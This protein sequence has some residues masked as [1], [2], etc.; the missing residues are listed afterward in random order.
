[1]ATLGTTPYPGQ[2][3]ES[4]G[5]HLNR[6]AEVV[7][8]KKIQNFIEPESGQTENLHTVFRRDYAEFLRGDGRILLPNKDLDTRW[9]SPDII[10][11]PLIDSHLYHHYQ[12]VASNFGQIGMIPDSSISGGSN[13][14]VLEISATISTKGRGGCTIVLNG[15]EGKYQFKQNPFKLG[16]T[17]FDSDD[18]VFV[19]LSGLDGQLHRVFTG[20]ITTVEAHTML[21]G[22]IKTQI[23]IHCD[24]SLKPLTQ[25]RTAVRPSANLSES[26][27]AKFVGLAESYNASM[28]HVVVSQIMGR[29][30]SNPYTIPG[31][32]DQLLE[33]R[34]RAIS[35]P[36]PSFAS[37]SATNP[38]AD[39]A[40]QEEQLRDSIVA[41][42]KPSSGLTPN[43]DYFIFSGPA[44][45][46]S[47]S[48]ANDTANGLVSAILQNPGSA[49]GSVPSYVFG[50]A[51]RQTPNFV[52][53]TDSFSLIRGVI[54]SVVKNGSGASNVD[55][56][57]LSFVVAGIKQ[58]TYR[59]MTTSDVPLLITDWKDGYS[60]CKT[61]ADQ[62]YFEF[63]ADAHGIAWFR[64]LNTKLPSDFKLDIFKRSTDELN[65]A[66]RVGIEYWLDAKYIQSPSYSDTDQGIYSIAYVAGDH[67]AA[68]EIGK[69]NVGIAVDL[70][71]FL[72]L[73]P[74]VAPVRTL[75]NVV[76]QEAV[77]AFARAYLSRINANA[78]T[79][80]LVYV[81]DS[82]I[83]VGNP[84]FIPTRNTIYY[85]SSITHN[86]V[87]GSTYTMSMELE[88]GRR[89]IAIDS[90]SP[91]NQNNPIA[92]LIKNPLLADL[93]AHK[94]L[95]TVLTEL[96]N[97]DS[98][99]PTIGNAT[100]IGGNLASGA[101]LEADYIAGN[102][103]E[104]TF[105]GY[106]WEPLYQLDF[107][108]LREMLNI[109][110]QVAARRGTSEQAYTGSGTYKLMKQSAAQALK[111]SYLANP[112][113]VKL[114]TY[115][116][117][118]SYGA[119]N[120]S[121]LFPVSGP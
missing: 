65:D 113:V 50:F 98:P 84:C 76:K 36:T 105:N 27:G 5:I 101:V 8:I 48:P 39:A 97:Q 13:G 35:A 32:Y 87:A 46:G 14:D 12:I 61:I 104:L 7:F 71:K 81:G 74:R 37:L 91:L 24:D 112:A 75:V 34:A 80:N 79:A 70:L 44:V 28:P 99:D 20:F 88:Y 23:T 116:T 66:S 103:S 77:Q 100:S 55:F 26:R 95:A 68:P 119:Q 4:N 42:P 111:V 40:V 38:Q 90:A 117:L 33:I 114:A 49:T 56:G 118:A 2:F 41:V 43:N 1:M 29:A 30:Y 78:S 63:F 19:S 3:P 17:V 93:M 89:P 47:L 16:K 73:G 102:L 10:P 94:S 69:V 51:R 21:G 110:R 9:Q 22:S 121:T 59:F 72:K 58:K 120:T 45:S 96:R 62:L 15:R 54:D 86:F 6:Q 107:D 11:G 106:V 31:F 60:I 57:D 115:T 92:Q 82:R 18:L 52:S 109:H 64:P 108:Q 67:E 85:I 25:S 53:A 83:Q